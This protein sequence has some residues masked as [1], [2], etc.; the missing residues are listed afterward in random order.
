MEASQ[1]LELQRYIRVAIVP[2]GNTSDNVTAAVQH[3]LSLTEYK[4]YK[5]MISRAVKLQ[6]IPEF[7][8]YSTRFKSIDYQSNTVNILYITQQTNFGEGVISPFEPF[9]VSFRFIW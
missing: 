9:F 7:E 6:D 2:L 8:I 1:T 5:L 3:R 4:S